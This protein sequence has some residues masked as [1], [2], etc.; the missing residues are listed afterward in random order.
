[1]E[2][3]SLES[4][5]RGEVVIM[6]CSEA[7]WSR[8][9]VEKSLLCHAVKQLGV[10]H[11]WRS[12][13]YAMQRS[14]LE[15]DTRGEVFIYVMQW[16]SLESD[17]RGEVFIYVMQWSSLESDTRGEVCH[18]VKQL[19]SGHNSFV[20]V[21]SIFVTVWSVER[22]GNRLSATKWVARVHYELKWLHAVRQLEQ[23]RSRGNS[24]VDWSV[25]W[26]ESQ[27]VNQLESH[28]VAL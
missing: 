7:A 14:S 27:T 11:A 20:V 28:A 16:S 19:G 9:R 25:V 23:W 26:L 2:W 10:G 22:Q 13:Y 6:S 1:M 5:T 24:E 8:A 21:A 4:D 17:T 15:S 3:S 18:A 12:L